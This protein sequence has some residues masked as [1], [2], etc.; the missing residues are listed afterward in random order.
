M[1]NE[2]GNIKLNLSVQAEQALKVISYITEKLKGVQEQ[3]VKVTSLSNYFD[4]LA[5][6]IQKSGDALLE[7]KSSE[8]VKLEKNLADVVLKANLSATSMGNLKKGILGAVSGSIPTIENLRKEINFLL[9][10][11]EN[12]TGQELEKVNQSLKR[13]TIQ[14][15]ELGNIGVSVV[16]QSEIDKVYNLDKSFKNAKGSL[17]Q[18]NKEIADLRSEQSM[19]ATNTKSW[20]KYE[21]QIN[22]VKTKKGILTGAYIK[23]TQEILNNKKALQSL[24]ETQQSA[25]PHFKGLV[26]EQ[27]KIISRFQQQTHATG[28]ANNVFIAFTQGIQDAPYG[29]RG[30]ANNIEFMAQSFVQLKSKTGGLSG[31]IQA[32]KASLTGINI[33]FLALSAG[34]AIWQYFSSKVEENAEKQK[35]KLDKLTESLNELKE[36]VANFNK[37]ALGGLSETGIKQARD[38]W[39]EWEEQGKK[40]VENRKKELE[41]LEKDFVAAEQKS[42]DTIIS[43]EMDEKDR[44]TK[45]V[46]KSKE[47]IA[48]E[49]QEKELIAE[50][51]KLKKNE[52]EIEE[53]RYNWNKMQR[54]ESD[55]ALNNLKLEEK[56]KATTAGFE[57]EDKDKDKEDKEDKKKDALKKI[58]DLKISYTEDEIERIDLEKGKKLK[59]LEEVRIAAGQMEAEVSGIK[60]G[61]ENEATNKIQEIKDKA[62][63]KAK[64]EEKAFVDFKNS[65]VTDEVELLKI[66]EKEKL[67]ILKENLLKGLL[68]F[69]E[70]NLLIKKIIEDTNKKEIEINKR[71]NDEIS[72]EEQELL[73]IKAGLLNEGFNV[74]QEFAAKGSELQKGLAVAQIATNLAMGYVQGLDI[75]QK[76]ATGTGPLAPYTFP[77]FY[78]QQILAVLTAVNSAKKALS[79]ATGGFTGDGGRYEEAGMVHRGEVVFEKPIVDKYKNP[80]LQMRAMMQSGQSFTPYNTSGYDMGTQRE[81]KALRNDMN[82]FMKQDRNVN[83]NLK[84]TLKGQRFLKD[85]MPSFK[86]FDK[87]KYV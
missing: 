22:E 84:G 23:V 82:M 57:K 71:K 54:E 59:E 55:K 62:F 27:G 25:N 33:A 58:E 40:S 7:L 50:K 28:Q 17:N 80:L 64:E 13:L 75:A 46:S 31:A 69:E 63:E 10:I 11:R 66:S 24:I 3:G 65:L 76:G 18:L 67:D 52:L 38:Q 9:N 73:N 83:V 85:E 15:Q 45:V 78:A 14:G 32:L 42:R 16:K 2:E 60:L 5:V 36:A 49:K 26:D 37:L 56:A 39:K 20:N 86:K 68:S 1:A 43:V 12:A 81:I 21:T 70:Y 77:I 41:K 35:E 79:F 72:R 47:Q 6:K 87:N 30:V 48:Q 19:V 34:L 74:A 53:E 8:L 51:I 4:R 29:I 61:I 44:I